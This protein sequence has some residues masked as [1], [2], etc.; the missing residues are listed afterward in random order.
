MLPVHM[1]YSLSLLHYCNIVHLV[2]GL[3]RGQPI[4]VPTSRFS[5]TAD[6]FSSFN[7][8]PELGHPTNPHEYL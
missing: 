5:D 4:V 6:I 8:D 3:S 1:Y 2:I 7:T